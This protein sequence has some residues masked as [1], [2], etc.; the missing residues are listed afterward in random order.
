M[1][2]VS[3]VPLSPLLMMVAVVLGIGFTALGA[4]CAVMLRA[5][6]T[7]AKRP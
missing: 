3:A 1:T 6:S 7:R 2:T 5:I 4:E